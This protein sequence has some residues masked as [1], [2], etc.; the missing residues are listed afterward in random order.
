[1]ESFSVS[2]QEQLFEQKQYSGK[3][4][5]V[6]CQIYRDCESKRCERILLI[7]ID[8]SFTPTKISCECYSVDFF[9]KNYCPK[10]PQTMAFANALIPILKES[11]EAKSTHIIVFDKKGSQCYGISEINMTP[12]DFFHAVGMYFIKL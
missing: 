8:F 3:A 12:D 4:K 6:V 5:E 1:M 7:H 9:E 2:N 11:K 10:T